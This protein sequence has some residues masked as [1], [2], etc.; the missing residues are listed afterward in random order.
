MRLPDRPFDLVVLVALAAVAPHL[1]RL[2]AWFGIALVT[3]ALLRRVAR[4]RG[5]GVMPA[6]QRVPLV[7]VI[8]AV[9]ILHYGSILGR[10]A[11]SALACG[12]LVLKLLE[13]DRVRDARALIGFSAFV[14]MTAL[15]FTQ[16]L[17]FTI[18][19]CLVLVVLLAALNSLEPAPLE[20]AAHPLR[21]GLRNGAL[22]A[23][24][25]LPLAAAAFLFTPRLG[26]P[27]WGAPGLD[28]FARTG[29]DDRMAPGSMTD[30]LVDDIPALRVRFNGPVPE[31][32]ARY[33]RA[34]VLWDFDGTTWTRD[35]TWRRAREETVE[36]LAPAIAYEVTLEPTDRPWLV[37]LDVP[38]EAPTDTRMVSDRTLVGRLR[39]ATPRQYPLT[40]TTRYR[41]ADTLEERDR[42][43][44][45]ALPAGFNP[46][47]RSLAADWRARNADDGA[48]VQAALGEFTKNFSYTLSPPLLGRD[49]VDDFLFSTRAGYCEHYSSAFVF[50]MRAAGIPARVVTGYQGGWYNPLGDYLLVRN[51]DAHAWAEVWLEG[52]GWVRVDPTAAVSPARV[53]RGGGAVGEASG[54]WGAAEWLRDLRNR[55]DVV[56]RLWTQ[57]IVQFNSLRQQSL[58]TPF[59]I[60]RAEQKDLVL[61]LAVSVALL[62]LAATAWVLRSGRRD[63]VDPIDAAWQ[64]L[65]EKLARHGVA[66][67][68]DEGPLALRQRVLPALGPDGPRQRVADLFDR[69]IALRYAEPSPEPERALAFASAVRELR[70]PRAVRKTRYGA[71]K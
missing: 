54:G 61:A 24:L 1:L 47:T 19:L 62:L 10:E 40:S 64:N 20:P 39:V 51:S 69:Y 52:R 26:A 21:A 56:N 11:G 44:A 6:W 41:L 27:L 12:L 68:D 66:T 16:T 31:P 29:L 14:L 46:R 2:P 36:A 65:R 49:S 22:L 58:L 42:R 37:A 43:R 35:S 57:T 71:T 30:L 48:I 53:E 55:L 45:L 28:A 5:A 50:L 32:A 18:L 4:R 15:L 63:R 17:G 7:G 13:T 8:V 3:L 34:I 59:G 60:D 23:G 70:L 33:F 9:I 25:G 67:R 38:L